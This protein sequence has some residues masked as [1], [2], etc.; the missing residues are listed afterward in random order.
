MSFQTLDIRSLQTAQVGTWGHL[1]LPTLRHVE[2]TS[3]TL[4]LWILIIKNI[5]KPKFTQQ[6][7]QSRQHPWCVTGITR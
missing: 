2:R 3:P 7:E 6:L 4:A 5:Q 1:L